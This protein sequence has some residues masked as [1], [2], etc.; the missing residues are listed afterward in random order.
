MDH[1]DHVRLLREGVTAGE[2]RADLGAG[3]GAF[4]LERTLR[5]RGAALRVILADLTKPVALP[6][7]DGIP[8]VNSLR[9]IREIAAR[10]GSRS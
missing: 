2:T 5:P 7:L 9:M 4:P 6:L 1:A 8:M 3:T 10:E